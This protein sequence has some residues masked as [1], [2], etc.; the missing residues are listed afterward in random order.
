MNVAVTVE[1]LGKMY[2]RYKTERPA[3]LQETFVRGLRGRGAPDSFWALH[4]VSFAVP[5]GQILGIVGSNGAGKSTLLRLI[6]GVGRPDAGKITVHGRLGA[7]LALGAGFHPDLTGRE[8]AYINGIIG[9]LTRRE[10]HRQFA[11]IVGFAE[12][13]DGIDNPLHTYSAGMRMRLAFAVAIHIQPEVLLVDEALSV[14]DLRFQRKCLDRIVA[15]KADGCAIL[16]VSHDLTLVRQL[17]DDVMWLRGG[18][19]VTCGPPDEVLG[20]YATGS[21]GAE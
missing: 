4:D 11:S 9:G 17:C 18:Q 19:V 1:K 21:T 7:L 16:L 5:P 13:E 12:L 20:Q 8:N 2:H 3:T 15:F 10:V 14:G 6:A